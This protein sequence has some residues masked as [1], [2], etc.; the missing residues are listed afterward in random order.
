MFYEENCCTWN[1]A[2][3]MCIVTNLE[4]RSHLSQEPRSNQHPNIF[5]R[6]SSNDILEHEQ[7]IREEN[8]K[9]NRETERNYL[10]TNG[11]EMPEAKTQIEIQK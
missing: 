2:N 8:A 3:S 10:N 11:Y 7:N 6:N 9:E 4:K 1:N 5:A